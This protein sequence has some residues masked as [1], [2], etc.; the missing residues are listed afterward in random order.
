MQ[1]LDQVTTES[2][3]FVMQ[4]PHCTLTDDFRDDKLCLKRHQGWCAPIAIQADSFENQKCMW[5]HHQF[6]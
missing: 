6:G 5:T 2:I 3:I 4:Q 1:S